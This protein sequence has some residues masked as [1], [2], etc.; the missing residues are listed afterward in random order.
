M[1]AF[2][3]TIAMICVV[4]TQRVASDVLL[5]Q[6]EQS[7]IF[8]NKLHC[9]DSASPGTTEITSFERSIFI[10]AYIL[11]NPSLHFLHQKE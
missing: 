6:L 10:L 5:F 4:V 8:F 7:L 3:I 2:S 9:E 11:H 1:L